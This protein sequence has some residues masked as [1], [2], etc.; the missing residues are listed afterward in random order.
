MAWNTAK[1]YVNVDVIQPSVLTIISEKKEIELRDFE[2]Y[3]DEHSDF[4]AYPSKQGS[5]AVIPFKTKEVRKG[6]NLDYTLMQ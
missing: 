2:Y 4:V 6:Q 1:L 3:I 5:I